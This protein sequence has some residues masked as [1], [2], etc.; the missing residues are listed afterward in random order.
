[1][2]TKSKSAS[3]LNSLIHTHNDRMEGYEHASKETNEMDL[4][5]LFTEHASTSR[6]FKAELTPH[7]LGA[8]DE[9]KKD[10]T[11]PGAAYQAWMD[12]RSALSTNDRKTV[13]K[14]CEFGEDFAV[15]AYE[16]VLNNDL[17]DL[18]PEQ[19]QIVRRQYSTIKA[20]H[21]KIKNLRDAVIAQS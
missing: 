13:L 11:A 14:S 8:G 21:D 6:K 10:R 3:I 20:Q 15:K 16:N 18:S 9:P 19:Q 12:V 1:M 4:K 2:E 5:N 17:N 7:V